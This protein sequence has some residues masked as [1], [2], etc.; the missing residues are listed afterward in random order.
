[1]TDREETPAGS[2]ALRHWRTTLTL[3]W[4]TNPRLVCAVLLVTVVV[5][6]VPAANVV[7][8]GQVVSSVAAAIERG[9]DDATRMALLGGLGLGGVALAV[10]VTA[11]LQQYC[12]TLLQLQMANRLNL[13]LMIKASSLSLQDYENAEI[14]DKLQLASKEVAFRPYQL[15]SD[16]VA[17]LT[18][19][20]SLIAL[21]TVLLV[22]NP[23]VALVILVAPIPSL[24]ATIIFGRKGWAIENSRAE[25]RR[26]GNYLQYLVTND[27]TF[28]E[29]RLLRLAPL[30]IRRVRQMYEDFYAVD[31]SLERGQSAATGYLGLL[32]VA[33]GAGAILLAVLDSISIGDIGRLA[34]Y[35]TAIGA[36]Q[37]SAQGVFAHVGQLYE[38]TL[39]LGNMF[40]FMDLSDRV[41]VHGTRRFPRPLRQG[42]EFRSV[43]FRYPDRDQDA[44]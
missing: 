19:T 1:M 11:V 33:A 3:L 15:F 25:L 21:A 26:R 12:E 22:W 6:L 31:K 7:V 30:L 37:A 13:D 10:H 5:A 36:V 24:A 39:F 41:E 38:H 29:V 9:E 40:G 16:L 17:G 20:V 4:T 32:G 28:K 35:L 34:G 14:Y 8:I 18:S 44:L 42:I 43:T 27:K 2:G 23:V